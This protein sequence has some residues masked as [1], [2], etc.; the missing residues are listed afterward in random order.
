VSWWCDS[1][2]LGTR[3][4]RNE[5]VVAIKAALDAAGIEIPYPYRT[6]HFRAPIPV[7]NESS[8]PG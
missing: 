4:S 8:K 3:K 6:L 7:E 1:T 2:P 5:I